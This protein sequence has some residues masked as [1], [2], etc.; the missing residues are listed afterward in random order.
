M[1]GRAAFF[2]KTLMTTTIDAGD[3][4]TLVNT[5][6]VAPENADRLI[7]MLADATDEVMRGRRGFISASLH[8]SDDGAKVIN[9]AQ[10]ASREDFDAM[11][12]DPEAQAHMKQCAELAESFDPVICKVVWAG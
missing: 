2:W 10:W 8:K 5:F 4:M 6:D 1:R 12:A 7:R 9:Y 3:V 11:R